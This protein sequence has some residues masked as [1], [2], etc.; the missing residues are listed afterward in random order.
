MEG[1]LSK[2]FGVHCAQ[3]TPHSETS[4]TSVTVATLLEP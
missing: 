4:P 2:A 1:L 3:D